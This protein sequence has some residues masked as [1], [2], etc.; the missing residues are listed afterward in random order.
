MAKK[1]ESPPQTRSSERRAKAQ[2]DGKP[3]D[4]ARKGQSENLW[5]ISQ[6]TSRALD[7]SDEEGP[8][9]QDFEGL[10]ILNMSCSS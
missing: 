3:P 8:T 2:T 7:Y 4:V 5:N 6:S 1:K 9:T 10:Q